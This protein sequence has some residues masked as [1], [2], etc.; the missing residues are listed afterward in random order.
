MT[1]IVD[2]LRDWTPRSELLLPLLN[3][4]ADK[5][6]RLRKDAERWKLLYRRA[7]NEANGLTNYAE[8]RPE[9][10]SAER[11]IKAIENEAR[12]E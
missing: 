11:R 10:R 9:L 1:D 2:R 8:D 3:E 7:I 12:A 6:E 5:I 4:S